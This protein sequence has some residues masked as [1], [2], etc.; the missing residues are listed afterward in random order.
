MLHQRAGA[1]RAP[2]DAGSARPSRE[3]NKAARTQITEKARDRQPE[4]DGVIAID[5]LEKKPAE[6][7]HP[8]GAYAR[9][10]LFSDRLE[11]GRDLGLAQIPHRELGGLGGF[12]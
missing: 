12:E 1:R 6:P 4:N 5:A 3:P 10:D 8:I 11:I 9:Q 2:T 7:L